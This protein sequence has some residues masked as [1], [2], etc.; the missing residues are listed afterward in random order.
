MSDCG[1]TNSGGKFFISSTS[2]NSD[3]SLSQ[4]GGLNWLEVPNLGNFGDTGVTQNVTSYDTW[5]RNVTCKGKGIANAGDPTGEFLDVPSSGMDAL[6]AAS[7]VNNQNNYAFKHEWADGSVE[8]NR[9]LVLGPTRP[10]G[11]NE[12]F[13]R[14][15]FTFA[16]NQEP[17]VNAAV[18]S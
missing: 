13:K 7:T 4:F 12:D 16:M 15:V 1:A 9:G 10:K 5:D 8:Y 18:S 14:V 2:Q 6:L 11:G 3:L 17:I